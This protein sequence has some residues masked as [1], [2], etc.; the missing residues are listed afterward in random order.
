MQVRTMLGTLLRISSRSGQR[1]VLSW[2][3]SFVLLPWGFCLLNILVL[4]IG[5]A[6]VSTQTKQTA[7]NGNL[8][9]VNFSV[10]HLT[11]FV[12]LHLFVL[13]GVVIL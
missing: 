5:H 7:Q 8:S 11:V 12:L 2:I 9:S 1:I 6:P 13:P 10:G 3:S 4:G